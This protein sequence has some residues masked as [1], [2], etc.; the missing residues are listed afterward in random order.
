MKRAIYIIVAFD[1]IYIY[2]MQWWIILTF[3]ILRVRKIGIGN[4]LIEKRGI[5]S[6]QKGEL[7][8]G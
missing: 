2:V 8:Q 7:A 1:Q 6:K 3:S 4:F 5:F